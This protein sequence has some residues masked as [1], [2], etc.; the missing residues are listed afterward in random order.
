[1]T[2]NGNP[3]DIAQDW[4]DK[5]DRELAGLDETA[6]DDLFNRFA[7]EIQ[8]AASRLLASIEAHHRDRAEF[9]GEC[10]FHLI[11]LDRYYREALGLDVR[12]ISRED[13]MAA[14]HTVEKATSDTQAGTFDPSS[15]PF[16]SHELSAAFF[17]AWR[18]YL[19]GLVEEGAL[20]SA[21]WPYL[22]EYY[23]AILKVYGDQHPDARLLEA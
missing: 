9:P 2:R 7:N 4:L 5:L 22:M 8:S 19:D 16:L 18:D 23:L 20:D 3:Q 14:L 10:L 6:L 21:I 13:L 15:Y 1:M 11:A 12:P 17:G